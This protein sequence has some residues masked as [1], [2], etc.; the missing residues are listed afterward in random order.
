MSSINL[1]KKAIEMP[2]SPIRKLQTY[3]DE[4]KS[5]GV[6]VY[7][8]NIGQPDINTP[9][10][11]FESM[12]KWDSQVLS[13]GPSNGIFELRKAVSNYLERFDANFLPSQ[14]VVTQGGSEAIVFAMQ[15]ICNPGEQIIVFEPFYTNYLGFSKMADVEL[16][17]VA[18]SVEDGF[19]IPKDE[20]IE[21]KITQRTRGIII[22]SPNNP[23]GTV[24]THEEMERIARLARKHDLFVL[25]DEVYREF[26]FDG[27]EH[28]GIYAFDNIADRAIVMDS[29]SKRF[30]M[31]GARIG[32]LATKNP[33]LSDAFLRFSQ[34]R[35]CPATV[36]QIG[37]LAGF[38]HY[39][40]FIPDMIKE[41]ENRRNTVYEEILKIKKAFTLKPEGAFYCVVKLPVDD[42]DEFAKFM[43]TDF[44]YEGQTT[45]VAPANGFYVSRDKGKNEIRIAY[46]LEEKRLK[47]AIDVLE[48]GI[49]AFN[50]R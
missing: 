16:V 44:N 49:E 34:A 8:L 9:K 40:E 20:V 32:Y 39:D 18:T 3:S 37:A 46:V 25:S 12:H 2:A 17:P 47:S 5:K 6:G 43:L 30:S 10:I 28:V 1:S 38:E 24:Y 27:K 13:Y 22:C 4:A 29:V 50:S 36:E 31:C 35:L 21:P 45:M 26:V 48:R 7:H 41:Y 11:I 33:T 14:I 42:A 15:A 23:T 19:R